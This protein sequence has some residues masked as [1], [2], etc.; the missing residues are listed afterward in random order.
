MSKPAT[1]DLTYVSLVLDVVGYLGVSGSERLLQ[2][3]RRTLVFL[4]CRVCDDF[5][6]TEPLHYHPATI[7]NAP[8]APEIKHKKTM[9]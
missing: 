6:S 4:T 3:V 9:R 7:T 5:L 1:V 2:E 8:Y